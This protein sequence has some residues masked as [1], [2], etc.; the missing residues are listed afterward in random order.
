MNEILTALSLRESTRQTHN[1]DLRMTPKEAEHKREDYTMTC[2]VW[3]TRSV[4]PALWRDHYGAIIMAPA[5]W[6][7]GNI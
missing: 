2:V 6:R 7:I 4:L 1:C 3:L 5:L